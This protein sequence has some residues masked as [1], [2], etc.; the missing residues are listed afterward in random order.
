MKG[1]KVTQ[2]GIVNGLDWVKDPYPH[3]PIGE[4]GRGRK[5]V[6]FPIA[7]QLAESVGDAR[8]D[9]ASV[10]KTKKKGTLLLIEEKN[11]EDRRALV[12]L[13]VEAGFRGGAEWTGPEKK[14]IPCDYQGNPEHIGVRLEKDGYFCRYCGTKLIPNEK[15]YGVTFNHPKEGTVF[16][17]PKLED[18]SGVQ[19]LAMGF[20]AQ[21]DA[22]RMGGHP[23]YLVILH[24]GTLLRVR[25]TGRLYGSPSEEF[26]HWDGETLKYGILDEI[27]PPSYEP[28]DGE[29]V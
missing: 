22:G 19:V 1:Y 3:V 13:A 28:E 20:R 7:A 11:P 17:Y 5:L 27:F 16:E 14:N 25:R 8:I 18:V 24:P 12:H 2:R 15:D 6:R 4:E 21:G 29:L 9:C 23:E 10:L 26:L